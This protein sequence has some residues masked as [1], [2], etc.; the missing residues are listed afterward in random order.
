M[1]TET[2]A[3]AGAAQT[4][5]VHATLATDE[6]A[7]IDA[8]TDAVVSHQ[9][10]E[11]IAKLEA[12]M[13]GNNAAAL[14]PA[15]TTKKEEA[16]QAESETATATGVQSEPTA[17]ATSEQPTTTETTETT[18][19]EPEPGGTPTGELEQPAETKLD[20]RV[21]LNHLGEPDKAK[22]N[23]IFALTRSGMSL[24]EATRR[25]MGNLDG[26]KPAETAETAQPQVPQHIADLESKLA[27]VRGRI[28]AE[29]DGGALNTPELDSLE[30]ERSVL[31]A[32][33]AVARNALETNQV[34]RQELTEADFQR[35]RTANLTSA[36]NAYPSMKD[37]T[38]TQWLVAKGIGEQMR[39]PAHPDHA[40]L[41]EPDAPL[42][43]ARKA[44][45]KLG[46]KPAG[47][48][49]TVATPQ[50]QAATQVQPQKAKPGPARGSNQSAPPTPQKTEE[51]ILAESKE[52]LEAVL[53]GRAVKAPS[54][55]AGGVLFLG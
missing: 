38:S 32:Q 36:V 4:P 8:Y 50:P 27:E 39:D 7:R 44:A 21:R 29:K 54:R 34:I 16:T 10:A 19:T 41:F 12:A 53:E 3:P 15:V 13:R 40:K 35:A 25:V 1:P 18:E 46:I 48:T 28:K 47:Q 51:Q 33:I 2:T 23:A 26:G 55:M 14:E 52:R 11:V 9:P 43:I 42:F 22:A 17:E 45:E 20:D 6:Q 49:A 31:I 37:K 24:E 30:D 5:E